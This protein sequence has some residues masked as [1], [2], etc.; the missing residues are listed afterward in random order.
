MEGSTLG[1]FSSDLGSHPGSVFMLME[2]VTQSFSVC[3]LPLKTGDCIMSWVP[4]MVAKMMQEV[5]S[6]GFVNARVPGGRSESGVRFL[7]HRPGEGTRLHGF[8]GQLT[9]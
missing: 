8:V 1:A 5:A 3:V 2:Q 7:Q 4:V 9:F 6:A